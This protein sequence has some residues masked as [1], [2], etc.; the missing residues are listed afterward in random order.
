MSR[1]ITAS[2]FLTLL[3][4]AVTA[5]TSARASTV[6]ANFDDVSPG[7]SFDYIFFGDEEETTAGIFN[8]VTI[9]GGDTDLGQFKAFC[10]ELTQTVAD[11]V[12]FDIMDVE[13]GP[14]PGLNV[15]GEGLEGPMGMSKAD[16]IRELWGRN[17]LDLFDGDFG[18]Q[19]DKAAAFQIA[20]WEIVYDDGVELDAGDFQAQDLE[21]DEVDLAQAWLDELDGTGPLAMNLIAL[22]NDEDPDGEGP[23]PGHRQDQLTMVPEPG[24]LGLLALGI[25]GALR[26]RRA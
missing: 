8:W 10:I 14:L 11:G 7:R 9:A 16:L 5:P 17:Y 15:P 20:V 1:R 21:D 4:T 12:L 22:T 26:R 6:K 2:L 18:E 19:A 25:L 13:D 3:A 23:L 24:T